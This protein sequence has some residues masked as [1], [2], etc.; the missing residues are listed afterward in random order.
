MFFK[1]NAP[2]SSRSDTEQY[3]A[4]QTSPV[5]E[6]KDKFH[7]WFKEQLPLAEALC[8]AVTFHVLGFPVMWFIGWA[9]PWPGAPV[10]MTVIE[11]N[12]EKWPKE[13][14]TEKVTDII[15]SKMHKY[16]K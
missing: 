4:V 14:K 2:K 12:L 13:A 16:D 8:V 5:E 15:L 10:I 1:R 6:F 9:L 3:F 7:L 11:I